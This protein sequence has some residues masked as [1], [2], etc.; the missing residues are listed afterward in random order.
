MNSVNNC[1]KTVSTLF[2]VVESNCC[3]IGPQNCN[4]QKQGPIFDLGSQILW[5]VS[6]AFFQSHTGLIKGSLRQEIEGIFFVSS[7]ACWSFPSEI[8]F[9]MQPEE[10]FQQLAWTW[11]VGRELHDEIEH[12]KEPPHNHWMDNDGSLFS[13][14]KEVSFTFRWSSSQRESPNRFN[15]LAASFSQW[16]IAC[17]LMKE[18]NALWI[19][20]GKA[21]RKGQPLLQQQALV[22]PNK[23]GRFQNID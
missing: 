10:Q 9:S 6:P 7:K 3:L 1:G 13:Q 17:P 20:Q 8:S 4:C 21:K 19:K 22:R 12:E 16:F 2:G 15:R 18:P 23:A 5:L 14:R 11:E